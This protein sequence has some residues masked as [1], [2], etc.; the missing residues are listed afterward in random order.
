MLECVVCPKLQ[1]AKLTF[2]DC[3]VSRQQWQ[4]FLKHKMLLQITMCPAATFLSYPI[5]VSSSKKCCFFVQ[6]NKYFSCKMVTSYQCHVV[7]VIA[8]S[9]LVF[10]SHWWSFS[11]HR[12]FNLPCAQTNF[13]ST[14]LACKVV[15]DVQTTVSTHTVQGQDPNMKTVSST[16]Q[17]LKVKLKLPTQW[18]PYQKQCAPEHLICRQNMQGQETFTLWYISSEYFDLKLK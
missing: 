17:H 9:N 2:T 18:Q 12:E 11:G 10:T 5:K 6:F 14:H 16:W 15:P 4:V 1:G 13:C 3:D 8:T 7:G